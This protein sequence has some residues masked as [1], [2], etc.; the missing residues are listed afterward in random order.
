MVIPPTL[1]QTFSIDKSQRIRTLTPVEAAREIK[2]LL[3]EGAIT[4]P[5]LA[6]ALSLKST[7]VLNDLLQLS[8]LPRH[9]QER[10][11]SPSWGVDRFNRTTRNQL[12][13]SAYSE[14]MR[15]V[16]STDTNQEIEIAL[17]AVTR[18]NFSKYDLRDVAFYRRIDATRNLQEA[19]EKV[20]FE[21]GAFAVKK[22]LIESQMII[23][24]VTGI[25]LS[26]R[27]KDTVSSRIE[28]TIGPIIDHISQKGRLLSITLAPNKI[29]QA[30]LNEMLSADE[31]QAL[32]DSI[33]KESN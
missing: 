29:T 28:K 9:L 3:S 27:Q 10:Y 5:H 14:F 2:R 30:K 21:K 23:V 4:L 1:H 22:R 32:V 18:L 31:V 15:A 19:I 13:F 26:Q 11:I 25:T 12:S 17:N 33:V 24:D 16:R 8:K 7:R 20:E 6:K